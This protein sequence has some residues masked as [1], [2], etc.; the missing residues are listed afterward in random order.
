MSDAFLFP[1]I[2]KTGPVENAKCTKP[3]T[4]Q[5]IQFQLVMHEAPAR[6][7]DR[8]YEALFPGKWS[9][10][11]AISGKSVVAAMRRDALTRGPNRYLCFH[12]EVFEHIIA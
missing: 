10:S 3:V 4:R 1:E 11:V 9:S 12:T 7:T 8:V 5:N 2:K 6:L